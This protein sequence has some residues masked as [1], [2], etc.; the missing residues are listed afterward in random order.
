MIFQVAVLQSLLSAKLSESLSHI[1]TLSSLVLF[2]AAVLMLGDNKDTE[3]CVEFVR[4]VREYVVFTEVDLFQ[5]KKI[6]RARQ[7][8]P[9]H[10][11]QPLQLFRLPGL[12]VI[13]FDV[14]V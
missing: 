2:V 10:L 7:P 1:C 4:S 11:G 9:Q 3:D 14:S 12:Q 13:L 5:K 6:D 8:S